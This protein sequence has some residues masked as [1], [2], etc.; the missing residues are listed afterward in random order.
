MWLLLVGG[1]TTGG[2][3]QDTAS[4]GRDP[5]WSVRA[6]YGHT[7]LHPQDART[8]WVDLRIG[9]TIRSPMT[10]IDFGIAGSGSRGG[11]TSVT[12]GFELRPLPRT[13][14]SPFVRAEIGVL[15]ESD[16]GGVVGGVGTGLFLHLHSGLGFRIGAAA[17]VH[18][19]TRGPVTYY[20]GLEYRW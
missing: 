7:R 17:N 15:G 4:A 14:I 6:I 1:F 11:F 3:S 5:R 13:R 9:R 10:S 19:L 12:S 2:W 20:G 16:F 8:D 18:G